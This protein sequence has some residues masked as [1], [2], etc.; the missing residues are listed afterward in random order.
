LEGRGYPPICAFE[1]TRR[2]VKSDVDM[3]QVELRVAGS[4]QCPAAVAL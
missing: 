3:D 1:K 2:T 4:L